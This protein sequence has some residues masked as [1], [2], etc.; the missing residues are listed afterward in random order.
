MLPNDDQMNEDARLARLVGSLDFAED[1]RTCP[2]QVQALLGALWRRRAENEL[3]TSEVF[4]QLHAELS[5]FPTPPRVLQLCADAISDE[6]FHA[7]IC[8]RMAEHYGCQ[9]APLA[10]PLPPRSPSFP[11]CSPRVHRALFAVLHCSVSETLAVTYLSACLAEASSSLLR[12]VLKQILQDEVRHSRIGW[13][14][15]A[16]P[17]L[18]QADRSSIARF[19]PALLDACVAVWL[20]DDA[21]Y[22]AEPPP[23]H[24]FLDQRGIATT[25][26]AA[27]D[28]VIL[29]G[30]EHLGLDAEP[31][32]AWADAW[33]RRALPE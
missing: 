27:I 10:A 12:A 29:P 11:V 18:S 20:A 22:P 30:L 23:G 13:A 14:V 17:E 2:P 26:A 24:G 28:G 25:V 6:V 8:A 21:E 33:S 9:P 7:K 31:A 5:R 15:L 3:R 16:A 4:L 32:R 1:A 19:M